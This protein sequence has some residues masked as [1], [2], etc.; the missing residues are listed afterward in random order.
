MAEVTI[1]QSK[2]PGVKEGR[3]RAVERAPGPLRL[4]ARRPS[5]RGRRLGVPSGARSAP[6]WCRP[7]LAG[8]ELNSGSAVGPWASHFRSEPQFSPT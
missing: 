7:A 5:R 3:G 4:P 8:R 6:T 2:L 1:D